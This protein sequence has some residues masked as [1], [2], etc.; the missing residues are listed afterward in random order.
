MTNYTV[1]VKVTGG[2]YQLGNIEAKNVTS[3]LQNLYEGFLTG[4]SGITVKMT[5]DN[6][7]LVIKCTELTNENE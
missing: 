5:G 7:E 3:A 6:L 1:E 4:Q 2:W